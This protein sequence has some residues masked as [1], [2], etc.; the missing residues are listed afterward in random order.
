MAGHDARQGGSAAGLLP[1]PAIP[2]PRLPPDL[3][4]QVDAHRALA[5]E[6]G[7]PPEPL[8]IR[9][10][11]LGLRPGLRDIPPGPLH[12]PPEVRS[13][14]PGGRPAPAC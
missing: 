5:A 3:V 8:G 2:G 1:R 9:P 13:I 14:P 7:I 10:E 11:L 6:L 12:V 4:E